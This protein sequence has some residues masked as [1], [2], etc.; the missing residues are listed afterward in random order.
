M[1]PRRA[2]RAPQPPSTCGA[3]SLRVGQT[4]N[5]ALASGVPVAVPRV[6]C[7]AEAYDGLLDRQR[8]MWSP[9]DARDMAA[10]IGRQL[11]AGG[12]REPPVVKDWATATDELLR[13]YMTCEA[14]AARKGRSRAARA[15]AS[16][17]L[18]AGYPFFWL[19]TAG[20]T[21]AVVCLSLLRTALNGVGLRDYC[22]IKARGA[23]G[24]RGAG[25]A[26]PPQPRHREPH[27][28]RV[29][30][31]RSV[32]GSFKRAASAPPERTPSPSRV[33]DPLHA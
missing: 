25:L 23:E 33:H 12:A 15:L 24:Q 31:A 20:V 1:Q 3:A 13:E 2:R 27:A 5:E 18:V 4:V 30:Q 17:A 21:L 7:F 22:A 28:H 14:G 19:L 6:G 8:D 29:S 32:K 9:G 16:G 26:A 11:Q 10:A